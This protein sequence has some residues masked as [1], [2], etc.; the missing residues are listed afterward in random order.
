MDSSAALPRPI[1][2]ALERGW[3]V[4][5]ANQRAARALHRDF[6]LDQ[7]AIGLTHW[8]PPAILAWDSWLAT[9]WHRLLLDGQ[10]SDLL[11]N[12]TQEHT[13]WRAIIAAD[14]VNDSLRSIDALA[15][16]AAEAWLLLHAYRARRRLQ[17]AVSSADTR[18]FARWAVGFDR[19]AVRAQYITQAQ[20]PEALRAAIE[21]GRLTPPT[22]LLLVGFD[23]KSPAQSALLDSIRATGTPIEEHC[24]Q[25]SGVPSIAATGDPGERSLF[26]G[27]A[28]RWVG[29]TDR[30]PDAT[31]SLT[32]VSALDVR[33][34]LYACAR[35]LR[36]FLT[37]RPTA[38]L[39]V[40][41]PSLESTRTVIDRIFR[42]VLAPELDNLAA[43]ANSGPYEF[44]LGIPL[45]QTPLV[46]TALDIL[47]WAIGPLPLDSVT[48]LLLSPHFAAASSD[49]EFLARAEFDAFV[50]RR[51]PLLQPL[52]SVDAL[53]T[54]A[55]NPKHGP[56][57]LPLLVEHL[58]ALRSIFQRS[59]FAN[60]E[61]APAQRTHAGWAASINEVLD[62]AGWST[63]SRDSSLE[64]QTRRKWLSTL[65]ELSTLDFDGARLP[66]AAALAALTHIASQ[67]LFA[68][69]SRHAPIQVL[70]PLESAGSNFDALWF[71][72]ASDLTWPARST[73][74]P[75]LPW[76]L[77]RELAMPGADPVHDTA[78]ARRITE[79]IAA[80]AGAVVFSFAQH[81]TGD[82]GHQRPSPVVLTLS[83]KP[84]LL[85]TEELA[86]AAPLPA[87]VALEPF[88][89]DAPIPTPPDRVLV[90]GAS[91]LAAQAACPFR[92][93]AEK[94][95]FAS[96]LE[97]PTLGLDA[98]Q[99]GSIV[100]SV[101]EEF[102]AKVETQSAL[103]LLTT[104][105]RDSL[106]TRCINRALA[107]HSPNPAL[108]WPRAYLDTERQRLLSLLI[109]WLE[110]EATQRPPFAVLAR[111][112][113]LNDVSIGSLRLNIR[114]DR[115]DRVVDQSD[116]AGEIILDYKTGLASTTDWLGP[117]P[118]APQLPLYAVVSTIANQKNSA[119]L[120]ALKGTGFCPSESSE[121]WDGALA[122]EGIFKATSPPP[123]IASQTLAAIAFATLRPG[124]D[125]GLHGYESREGIL[126]RPAKLKTESLEDQLAEWHSV[127]TSLAA[128]FHSGNARVD[129]KKYPQTCAHCDQRLLCRLNPAA[130]DAESG[131][132]TEA[133]EAPL[134]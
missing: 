54:L 85:T 96:A 127:L 52:L 113:Q 11:L 62:A 80:S 2:Q 50:L 56:A 17:A 116:P 69:E 23:S 38:R 6:N 94:R 110:F 89:D 29:S 63:P 88:P 109:L 76:P 67:T 40:I 60:S 77:Q 122:P 16:L 22:G 25:I 121:I 53:L 1:Q 48:S 111:E 79:R 75:L 71:L 70:G 47:R 125:L 102:W 68:P 24:P 66:F 86:P 7:R 58:R 12:S 132:E 100:H 112:R 90:G 115:I 51:Q 84:N 27:V 74:N 19:H 33:A 99:R 46:S 5:T 124:K 129:P 42:Q 26:A 83:T 97:V 4:V 72:G 104:G 105:Q 34:E 15:E 98:A 120:T 64:F 13:L 128:D 123:E 65:D 39:A 57:N 118:D 131:A 126:P 18:A 20:L 9:L 28:E 35:W 133:E 106:L 14:P 92:A 10:A 37:E 61:R 95:L 108:G 32:L 114:V 21:A 107:E 103:K 73:P 81:S 30:E 44:S 8:Q 82:N 119:Q 87:P 49:D 93:F 31:P 130:L 3:T 55:A 101:L 43:P 45:S 134:A 36:A 41:V 117:R 78:H 59:E 91:V